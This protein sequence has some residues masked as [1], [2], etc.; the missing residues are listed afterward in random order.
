MSFFVL[1][2][3]IILLLQGE[4]GG[5][6]GAPAFQAINHG[7]YRPSATFSAGMYLMFCTFVPI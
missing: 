5:G 7:T 2:V 3:A 4:Q 6:G 1:F